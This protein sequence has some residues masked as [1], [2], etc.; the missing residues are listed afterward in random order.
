ME[1]EAE[2]DLDCSPVRA[3]SISPI[4]PRAVSMRKSED[5]GG[6]SIRPLSY[7]KGVDISE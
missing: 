1:E 6:H 7:E 5:V 4:Y 2:P 3:V